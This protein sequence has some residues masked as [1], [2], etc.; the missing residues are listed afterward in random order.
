YSKT[1]AR[2]LTERW[3]AELGDRERLARTPRLRGAAERWS[4]RRDPGR[5]FLTGCSRVWL[6]YWYKLPRIVSA[7][8]A[9]TFTQTMCGVCGVCV[10]LLLG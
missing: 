6:F 2:G 9:C 10:S 3:K 8:Y 5:A 7:L 1:V 4:P